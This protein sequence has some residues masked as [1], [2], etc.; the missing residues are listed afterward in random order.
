MIDKAAQISAG[1]L[2]VHRLKHHGV[3]PGIDQ[4]LVA[5][6]GLELALVHFRYDDLVVRL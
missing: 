2:P 3:D 1:A 4:I 6:Q 5:E